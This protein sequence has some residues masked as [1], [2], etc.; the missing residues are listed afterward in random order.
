MNELTK[1]WIEAGKKLAINP[2]DKVPCPNCGHKYLDV[3]DVRNENNL[4]ELERYMSC[5]ACGSSNILRLV[6][7]V[8]S[9]SS[10]K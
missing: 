1:K 6:R 3:F 4:Q 2:D 8:E 7:D 10:L 5:D 9:P